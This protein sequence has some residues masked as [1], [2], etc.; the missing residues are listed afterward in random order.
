MLVCQEEAMGANLYCDERPYHLRA[1][2]HI[3]SLQLLIPDP[4]P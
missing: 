1:S 4:D 2:R 3:H